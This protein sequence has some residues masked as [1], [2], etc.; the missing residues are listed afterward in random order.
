MDW[1]NVIVSFSEDEVIIDDASSDTVRYDQYAIVMVPRQETYY[2]QGE[3][4]WGLNFIQP[5]YA[6]SP[7]TPKTDER[8]ERITVLSSRDFD[9][10]H[11]AGTDLAGLFDVVVN[12]GWY[13]SQEPM[14]LVDYL[15]TDPLVA[16]QII[17]VLTS[18]PEITTGFEFLVE[19]YQ[20]GVEDNDF[21]S[22]TTD[23]I[24]I[25]KGE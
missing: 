7:V 22:F 6:C 19:Y 13:Y 2:G 15:K 12:E 18:E 4:G 16:A 9:A 23:Q 3:K 10:D 24:V 17:L 1:Y 21:Y 25:K 5:T 8:V 11:P 14:R 20:D